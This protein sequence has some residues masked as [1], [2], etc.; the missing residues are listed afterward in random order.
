MIKLI[1]SLMQQKLFVNLMVALI[2]LSG[3]A[4]AER[5]NREAYPE[6]NFDMV[7][8]TTIYPGGSPDEIEKLISI[9]IEK[10][11]REV[12]NLDKVRTY[13]I[14]NVS[15]LAIYIED[16]ASNKDEVVQDIKDA[17]ELVENLPDK[18]ETPLVKEL[19]FDNTPA[20]DV[21]IYGKRPDVP[22]PLIREAANELEDFLYDIEGVA[23]VEDFGYYDKE[24]LV[25]VNPNSLKKYR[26]GLNDIIRTLKNRNLDF[27][28]GSLKI[29]DKEY[30]LRTMGQYKNADEIRNSII[31]S[32]D[33]GFITRIKDVATVTDTYEEA[34][35]Y[36]R[37]NGNKA[38]IYKIWKKRSADEIR[39]VD[40][41]KK[42]LKE[43]KPLNSDYVVIETFNDTSR[44][45]R[46]RIESIQ[47]NAI[48]GFILLALILMLLLGLRMSTI[49]TFSIPVAFMAAF[50]GMKL[51]DITLNVVSM[52]GMIMVLGMIVDFGIV[53]SENSHRYM[54]KGLLRTEA[55]ENGVAEV[56]WPVTVTLL[57][58]C[59]AFAPLLLL[60]GLMGKFIKGIPIVLMMCLT[61]SWIIAM[62]I[63]PIHLDMFSKENHKKNRN[64]DLIKEDEYFE[65][66]Y[67]GKIQ[68]VY[69]KILTWIL[70]HR[71]ITTA[72]L[73]ILLGISL[74][75]S[76]VIGFVF[77][78][79]GGEEI[80][81]I[82]IKMPQETNL[83]ANLREI[84][85]LEK[86]IISTVPKDEITDLHAIVGRIQY[87]LIDP[88]P[89]EGTH[90]SM[91]LGY[92]VPEKERNRM[93]NDIL[94][95]VRKVVLKAQ[96]DGLISK[97]IS[98]EFELMSNG[99]PIGKPVNVEI[100]GKEFSMLK[101]IAHE[102]MDYLNSIDGVIDITMDLEEGKQ[103]YRYQI[104][105][106]MASRTG[107]SMF[108]AAIALNS[109]FEGAIASSV[110]NDEEDI[111]I[112]VRFPEKAR[113]MKQ[114][115]N[116]V[117]IANQKGGLI[118]L[119]MVTKVIKQPGYT[120]I[121][122]LNYK[123]LV[124]VQAEVNTDI[125]TSLEVNEMLAKRFQDIG[126][127]YPN[128]TVS[129][130]GEKEDTDENMRELRIL[131]LYAL[132]VIYI[133]IAVFF[134]S[135]MLPVVVMIA[136]PFSLVGVVIA[137]WLHGEPMS[138]MSTLG[139]FS[140]A[141][142]IVSNTLVLVRF[143]NNLRDEGLSL[144][145]ALI[146]GGVIRL[147]PVLLT[148][149]TTVLALFPTIY[150][151]GGKD[152][153]VAPLAL[154]FGYGLIFATFITL[155]LIPSFYH[156]A[157]DIKGATA[158]IA[159]FVG[160]HMS[161]EIYSTKQINDSTAIPSKKTRSKK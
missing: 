44:F 141:G 55:I 1:H 130:G 113:K 50:F 76:N 28:G 10:K 78:P 83:D 7:T 94:N 30:I 56:F 153:F 87:L 142:V 64:N 54:E 102:Y 128:Y 68:A 75:L 161:G 156:I 106:V 79:G 111:D 119:S 65:K 157:E 41:I 109:S 45:T 91:I 40:K 131:F 135:L 114:S 12:D 26:I 67:F 39:L 145:D 149:G 49:V 13:N 29:G 8:V 5:I 52:F 42:D 6:V 20:I 92:L 17:V 95:E 117:M 112:R 93:A 37:F 58:I 19:K 108:D 22:Y 154:A 63:M 3:Y 31:I 97:K 134:G 129:Y 70:N 89:G 136:I 152:Y 27:P 127:R 21:A 57:C 139:V 33:A 4:I 25:E 124:Q 23:D 14:E 80:F 123:R 32:N 159:S 2:I 51:G 98:F 11:L 133:I 101:K 71:Y 62:F 86:I 48:S 47:T 105:E 115:L 36:E 43:Y 140:L 69:K 110:R 66:G 137:L 35:F 120:Q 59:A 85:K 155:I 38:I 53:V 88:Q 107:V 150:S 60:T 146:E 121:N 148:T 151:I 61:A 72:I 73:V 96:E 143:I 46:E 138:F 82:K 158:K 104:N 122:R 18:A 132:I 9:P 24:Y 160:I 116:K 81:M 34:D 99:P 74:Y 84:K 125:I 144:K 15:V 16:D 77:M 118:P 100:Q 126:D 147:R 103:E 90:K